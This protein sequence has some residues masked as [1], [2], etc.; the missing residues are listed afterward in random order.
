M[1]R[2]QNVR[3]IDLPS[4]HDSRG[5]LTAVEGNIDIPFNIERI[6]YMHHV[7]ADRGGHA[8]TDTDQVIVASSGSFKVDLSDGTA[9]ETYELN[10]ATKGLYVPR[11]VFIDLHAFSVDAVCLVLASTHY[12]MSKSVRSWQQ[13]LTALTGEPDAE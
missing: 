10:D 1:K 9:V 5:V 8:H 12:D 3:W 13:Y 4:H 7:V 6:F 2:L 11:M